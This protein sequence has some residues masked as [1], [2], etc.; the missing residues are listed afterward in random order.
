MSKP[1]VPRERGAEP[2]AQNSAEEAY[3]V[4]DITQSRIHKNLHGDI[5]AEFKVK[6]KGYTEKTWEPLESLYKTC[7]LLIEKLEMKGRQKLQTDLNKCQLGKGGVKNNRAFPVI[8][9][10]FLKHFKHAIEHVPTGNETIR[11]ILYVTQDDERNVFWAMRFMNDSNFYFVR[12]CI[13]EY[14]YPVAASMF[15]EYLSRKTVGN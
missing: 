12:K 6:W 1:R 4:E 13:A 9:K 10:E 3:E 7:P 2:S 8:P 14:Y 15:H 11:D 5:R